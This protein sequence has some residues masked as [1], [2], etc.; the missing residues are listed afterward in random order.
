MLRFL[1][2]KV[3]DLQIDDEYATVGLKQ[4]IQEAAM[5]IREK[6]IPYLIA[7]EKGKAKG[8]LSDRDILEKVV[9][10]GKGVQET[11]VEHV[12]N[13]ILEVT[14]EHTADYCLEKLAEHRL[15]A[16]AVVDEKKELIGVA[17]LTDCLGVGTIFDLSDEHLV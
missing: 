9:A 14:M 11:K 10:E 8:L 5:I 16:L 15:P 3:K 17:T 12:M 6:N 13:Q 1:A 2:V 4:T 7:L